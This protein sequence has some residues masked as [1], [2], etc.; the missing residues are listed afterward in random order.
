MLVAGIFLQEFVGTAADGA[1]KI[2]WAHLDIAGTGT[3][4][5]A[6]YGV[7]GDGGTGASVRTVLQL[8]ENL[9]VARLR[10]HREGRFSPGSGPSSPGAGAVM[11]ADG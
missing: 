7:V 4:N 8:V 9:A 2:P 6:G 1:A 10:R 11:T 5:G 3:N